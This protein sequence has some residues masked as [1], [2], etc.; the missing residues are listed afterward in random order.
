MSQTFEESFPAIGT[1][2]QVV[3]TSLKDLGVARFALE[4][5]LDAIDR[6]CSRFRDDSELSYVNAAAGARVEVTPLFAEAL[7]VALRAARVT[8]GLVD[9]TVGRALV[10]IGYDRDF[11][12][13]CRTGSISRFEPAPGWTFVE[14]DEAASTV[15][16]P[17]GIAL[18]L[19]ATAKALAA[20]RAARTASERTGNG[21]LVN[22]GGD[23]AVAGRPPKEGWHVRVTHDHRTA[24]G[25]PGQTVSIRSG[26]LATSSTTVRRWRTGTGFAHHIVDPSTGK[27]ARE[28]WETVSVAAATCVDANTAAT[29]SIVMGSDA[30]LWLAVQ[31]LPS[32]LVDPEG[33]IVRVAGWPEDGP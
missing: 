7:G 30:P 14:L 21:V 24:V 20:D 10:T 25:A 17:A 1:T 4:A 3:T 22:L 23:I 31:D 6:A 9:P 11:A 15:R 2:A 33:N 28:V 16:M 5:E 26:G 29:A 18:D 12:S 8:R 27:P 32:R 19:G 13:I